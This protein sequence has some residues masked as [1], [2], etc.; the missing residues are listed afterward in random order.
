MEKGRKFDVDFLLLLLRIDINHTIYK[1]LL[2]ILVVFGI[3]CLKIVFEIL[4]KKTKN[5]TLL[6]MD[7]L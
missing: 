2:I 4:K 6:K 3:F 5:N 1:N 7:Y